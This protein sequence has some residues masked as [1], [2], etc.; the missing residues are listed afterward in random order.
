[1]I[2]VIV[3]LN[4][5]RLHLHFVFSRGFILVYSLIIV[6]TFVGILIS[7]NLDLGYYY[8]DGFKEEYYLFYLS[9]SFLIIEVIITILIVF[10]SAIICSRNN[11]YL[12]YYSTQT[13]SQRFVFL[14]SRYLLG[15]IIT[16][17]TV[18]LSVFFM[19]LVG[20]YLT[21][22]RLEMEMISEVIPFVIV[23]IITF[24]FMVY[25][26]MSILNNF[27]VNGLILMIFWYHKTIMNFYN[28]EVIE[29]L[30]LKTI[31]SFQ[32]VEDQIIV[33]QELHLYLGFSLSLIAFAF[34]INLFKDCK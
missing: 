6:I 19:V 5:L 15:V 20:E 31:P 18:L 24:Q 32:L 16:I 30:L 25:F 26:L 29:D 17:V 34:V 14:L 22:F 2:T 23:K 4:Y 12:I 3:M 1:M 9:Q 21:P 11:D 27:L 28:P 8:L 13:F 10:V 7:A 33:Y